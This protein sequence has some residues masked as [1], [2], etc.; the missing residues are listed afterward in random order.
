MNLKVHREKPT[1][2]V[3][4]VVRKAPSG[5]Q[6]SQCHFCAFLVPSKDIVEHMEDHH[7]DFMLAISDER[8]L[9]KS[10]ILYFC[11]HCQ[12][13][14]LDRTF[15]WIHFEASHDIRVIVPSENLIDSDHELE[16]LPLT[17]ENMVHLDRVYMCLKCHKLLESENIMISHLVQCHPKD[18]LCKGNFVQAI[19]ATKPKN[20]SKPLT[21]HCLVMDDAFGAYRKL[22]YICVICKSI[23]F[24]AHL[25]WFHF[26][27]FHVKK[28]LH[29][30]Y[31]KD[32]C[33]Q[34]FIKESQFCEHMKQRHNSL[35]I[36]H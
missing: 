17:L 19:A 29:M 12:Y 6:L 22:C 30:V 10:L 2:V 9:M 13:V 8:Q 36:K 20:I 1:V 33:K 35:A 26:I 4:V 7:S 21:N 28:I 5:S 11:R 23:V 25:A 32:S 31:M 27:C 14:T 16:V 15:M 34:R 24:K 18:D 3:D